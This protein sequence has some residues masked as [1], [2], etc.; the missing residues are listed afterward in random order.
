MLTAIA[1]LDIVELA[2]ARSQPWSGLAR[3]GPSVCLSYCRCARRRSRQVSRRACANVLEPGAFFLQNLF[4]RLRCDH[5]RS[6]LHHVHFPIPDS[7]ALAIGLR[8]AAELTCAVHSCTGRCDEKEDLGDLRSSELSPP[9]RSVAAEGERTPSRCAPPHPHA[10]VLA[11]RRPKLQTRLHRL[12]PSTVVVAGVL[13]L[14]LSCCQCRR[15]FGHGRCPGHQ[16][17]ADQQSPGGQ[18]SPGH[19]RSPAVAR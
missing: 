14:L 11:N 6:F 10:R 16:R 4:S 2:V 15:N 18:Q 19:Q 17:R 3:H 12:T 5:A 1:R 13:S 9:S 7:H 8:S